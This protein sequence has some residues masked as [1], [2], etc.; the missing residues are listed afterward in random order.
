VNTALAKEIGATAEMLG[1]VGAFWPIILL[2]VATLCAL[3]FMR[4]TGQRRL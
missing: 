3:G 1:V 2:I 4:T